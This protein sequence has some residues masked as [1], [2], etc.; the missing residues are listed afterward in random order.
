M[1]DLH[2]KE[3]E[4]ENSH[5]LPQEWHCREP[6]CESSPIAPT[7]LEK[8]GLISHYQQFHGF[9]PESLQVQV[10]TP[11]SVECLPPLS[12][13]TE[14]KQHQ[15]HQ[16]QHQLH[17]QQHQQQQQQH[18]MQSISQQHPLPQ[19]PYP[20]S[21]S[22]PQQQALPTVREPLYKGPSIIDRITGAGY[23]A[24][25]RIE[26]PV[27]ECGYRFAREYDMKRHAKAVHPHVVIGDMTGT[28]KAPEPSP[29]SN[30]NADAGQ[31]NSAAAKFKFHMPP[32]LSA[33]AELSPGPNRHPHP[34][35]HPASSSSSPATYSIKHEDLDVPSPLDQHQ[36]LPPPL[37]YHSQSQAQP[38]PQAYSGQQSQSHMLPSFDQGVNGFDYLPQELSL[39]GFSSVLL[40]S[41]LLNEPSSNGSGPAAHHLTGYSQGQG[42]P[43]HNPHQSY[44][45]GQPQAQQ[46]QQRHQQRGEFERI[47]PMIVNSSV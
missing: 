9:V 2:V 20:L 4:L 19:L 18:F 38:L 42:A 35:A 25:R 16:Q 22:A 13:I 37:Q 5:L 47:D 45:T 31:F 32:S 27:Q 28:S 15:Q 36:S 7:F 1:L 34:H 10:Q 24:N 21:Y 17:Q 43:S 11:A 30:V 39:G 46:Q 8:D 33:H 6:Q 14:Q 12:A 29:V 41:D 40:S 23:D 3:H 26:C 44:G